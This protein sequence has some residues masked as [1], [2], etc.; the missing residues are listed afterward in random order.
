MNIFR[1]N[2]S[3]TQERQEWSLFLFSKGLQS[4]LD[5]SGHGRTTATL[6]EQSYHT[7]PSPQT[8]RPWL[9]TP[10]LKKDEE[11]SNPASQCSADTPNFNKTRFLLFVQY[12]NTVL[13]GLELRSPDTEAIENNF[14]SLLFTF[15]YKEWIT[16]WLPLQLRI[17]FHCCFHVEPPGP[18]YIPNVRRKDGYDSA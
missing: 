10:V 4:K 3:S 16:L 12:R 1:T 6:T 7:S 14:D 13:L 2:V 5:K 9:P 17:N 8:K 18:P 15:I 11:L